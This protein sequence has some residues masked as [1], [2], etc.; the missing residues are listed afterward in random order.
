MIENFRQSVIVAELCRPLNIFEKFVYFKNDPYG[1]LSKNS[2]PRHRS[3][4]CI[5]ISWNLADR[6][7]VKSCVAYTWQKTTTTFCLGSPAVATA[8]IAPKI[9][10][11]QPRQSSDNVLRVLQIW[12]KSVDFRRSYSH[13]RKH[14]HE[15]W[16]MRPLVYGWRSIPNLLRRF[17]L[18]LWLGYEDVDL[19]KLSL[20]F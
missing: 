4:C 7:S 6:K 3:T 18:E 15:I 5:Q 20:N 9:C 8:L 10:H 14:T 13:K 19:A 17:W 11:G 12:S 2:D 1:K 16:S